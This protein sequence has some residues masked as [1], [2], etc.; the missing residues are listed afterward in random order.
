MSHPGPPINKELDRQ[1]FV[2]ISMGASFS[3]IAQKL[4]LG[5]GAVAGRV[6][7]MKS[8]GDLPDIDLRSGKPAKHKKR[9]PRSKRR[10]TKLPKLVELKTNQCHWPFGHPKDI[11][12]GFCGDAVAPGK[13]YCAK[14]CAQ[15]YV[16]LEKT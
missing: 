4:G 11:D 8:R 5:R 9:G 2:L 15:S 1:F 14:H 7:R 10:T 16:R 13:S 6:A 3:D 12:F